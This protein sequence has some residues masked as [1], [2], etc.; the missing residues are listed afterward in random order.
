G[1]THEG[2]KP[3]WSL[4]SMGDTGNGFLSAIGVIQALYHRARTG[5][6]Q[7]VD[8]SILNAGLLAASMA[9]VKADGTSV[10]RPRLDH[11]QL[12]LHPLYR[13]YQTANGWVR[14]APTGDEHW[15]GLL[16]ALGEPALGEDPR[17]VDAA[18]RAVHRLELDEAL[19]PVF[20]GQPPAAVFAPPAR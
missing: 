5:E 16:D 7:S 20:R 8:T 1:G 19:E 14:I 9:S 13:L 11:L 4:T 15:R 18:A 2:G 6:A 3:F 12:G 10:A 17:F